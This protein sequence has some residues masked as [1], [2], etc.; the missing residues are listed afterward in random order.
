MSYID[1]KQIEKR[2]LL[3]VENYFIKSKVVH[4]Y[5]SENDKEPFWDGHFYLY[6]NE[7]KTK[8]NFIGR[9]AV[10]VK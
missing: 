7:R 1:S 9:I 8:D 3:A 2:A 6:S 5:L 4:T 10:Q